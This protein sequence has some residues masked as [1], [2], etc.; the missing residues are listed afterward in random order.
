VQCSTPQGSQNET[1]D[2]RTLQKGWATAGSF[3]LSIFG[4]LRTIICGKRKT[5]TK[6]SDQSKAIIT[7]VA[8]F[9]AN[10]LGISAATSTALAALILVTLAQATMNASCKM[11]DIQVY[12]ARKQAE[13]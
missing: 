11:D 10:K 3:I 9:L 13:E 4:E 12:K 5:P 8:V 1:K 6:L 2:P 7:G